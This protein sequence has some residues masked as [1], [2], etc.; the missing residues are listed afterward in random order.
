MTSKML[1]T[2]QAAQICSVTSDTVLKWIR[3]GRLPA[4]RTPGGHHRVSK[5][6]LMRV[7][8]SEQ[9]HTE[10]LRQDFKRTAFRYCWEF[11]GKGKLLEGCQECVVYQMRAKRCYEVVERAKEIGHNKLFCK[12]SCQECEYYQVVHLQKA[13]LLVVTDNQILAADLQR[14]AY[15][16]GFNLEISNCEYHTSAL[17]NLFRPDFAIV[18]CSLGPQI[19]QDICNHLVEDPRIPFIRVILAGDEDEFPVEC[20]REVFARMEKPFCMKDVAQCIKGQWKQK[21]I[22]S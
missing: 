10:N 8:T 20:D 22:N 17:V 9:Q 16:E 18:D 7:L 5:R 1:T 12:S 3:S 19:A 14:G 4:T 13:N 2:G 11:N 21:A 6:D 15:S